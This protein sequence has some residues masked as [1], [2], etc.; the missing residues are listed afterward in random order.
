[1]RIPDTAKVLRGKEKV[2]ALSRYARQS[3]MSSAVESNLSISNFRKDE[4]GVPKPVGG[5]FWSIS[6]K[7][8]MVAGVVSTGCVGIDI[9][10]IKTVSNGLFGRVLDQDEVKVLGNFDSEMAFFRAFTAKE[11]VLKKTG[12][13]IRG[14]SKTKIIDVL[15]EATLVVGYSGKKY[16]VENFYFDGYLAAV[17]K[18]KFNIKWIIE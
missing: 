5:V 4:K 2:V 15:D 11:A 6:H 16:R 13:G 9:E 17:T 3:A 10:K 14:L 1:M 8:E 7:E 12:I 18:N